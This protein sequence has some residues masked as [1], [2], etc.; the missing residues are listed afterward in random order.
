MLSTRLVRV[1]SGEIAKRANQEI[2]VP[3]GAICPCCH[4]ASA[5]G[6]GLESDAR[7]EVVT[8]SEL[9]H[10]ILLVTLRMIFIKYCGCVT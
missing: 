1:T 8:L 9:G 6:V 10:L 5:A 3:R 4:A 7:G 2:G